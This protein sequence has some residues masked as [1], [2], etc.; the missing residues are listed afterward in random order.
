MNQFKEK[1]SI[2]YGDYSGYISLDGHGRTILH[3]LCKDKNID[4][5]YFPIAFKINEYSVAETPFN[6]CVNITIYTINK[7][8]AGNTLDEISTYI[9]SND[10]IVNVKK[11]D[12]ELKY[13]ELSKYF[14]RMGIFAIQNELENIIE[15]MIEE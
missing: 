13:S 5:Q 11:I 2:K 8:E 12:I 3:Q 4:N 9:K 10:G 14:K 7:D 6:N 1:A 15:E